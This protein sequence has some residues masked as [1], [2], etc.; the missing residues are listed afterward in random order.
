M[1]NQEQ[2]NKKKKLQNAL[3]ANLMRRK[4]ISNQQH[5]TKNTKTKK[6]D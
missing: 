1:A 2:E 5:L 3:R 4:Q 6:N